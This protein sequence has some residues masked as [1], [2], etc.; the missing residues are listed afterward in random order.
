MA[1]VDIIIRAFD[2]TGDAFKNVMSKTDS[3]EKTGATLQKVGLGMAAVGGV[4]TAGMV[5]AINTFRDFEYAM[6]NVQ[7]VSGAT[8]EELK[9]LTDF[10]RE[11]G[12]TTQ[13]S[14]KEVAEAQYYL[15]SAGLKTEE[16]MSTLGNVLNLAA[17]TQSDLARTSEM[18]TA[19]L[20]Q[21][22]LTAEESSRV[23][24]V[25]MKAISNSQATMDKLAYSMRY[26]GPVANSLGITLE[27]TTAYLMALYNAG[28][29]GE[30]AGTIL[31]G[32]FSRLLDVSGE[33]AE[34]LKQLGLS[35]EDVNPKMHSF[36]DILDKLANAG[37][38]TSEI[39]KIF[40]MEA[41]PGVAALMSIG[42]DEIAKYQEALEGAGGTAERAAKEQIN[43]LQGSLAILKSAF[44]E[45]QLSLAETVIPIV[46]DFVKKL[47]GLV[48]WFNQLPEPIK[49]V[50]GQFT[51]FGGVGLTVAGTLT[52]ITGTLMKLGAQFPILLSAASSTF[53]GISAGL[54]LLATNPQW[55]AITLAITGIITVI[56]LLYKNWDKV[57]AFFKVTGKII[58][59]LFEGIFD[60]LGKGWDVLIKGISELW[61]NY[62][63][64]LKS[65]V[66]FIVTIFAPIGEFFRKVFVGWIDEVKDNWNKL[67][68]F[69]K[70]L[71]N[72]FVE[73]WR[74][75]FEALK[76][77]FFGWVDA[78]KGAFDSVLGFFR[79]IGDGISWIWHKVVDGAKKMS[80]ALVGH[81]IIPDMVKDIEKEF[82]AMGGFAEVIAT[83]ISQSFKKNLSDVSVV[84][85]AQGG[86][87]GSGTNVRNNI[88]IQVKEVADLSKLLKALSQGV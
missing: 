88:T 54:K 27:E 26:V 35:V 1:N 69:I 67:I 47:T 30:Q 66:N 70:A 37:A 51:L 76:K 45:L 85:V 65:V 58:V 72:G 81:S 41:G 11:M 84:G 57:V 40:G 17:G 9:K 14:A 56:T 60:V 13:F 74:G 52:M 16:I 86:R 63:D 21:F 12:T 10:A 29:K 25:F 34:T 75:V 33:A 53:K 83:D 32:A 2:K 71:W 19:T 3:L 5:S 49:K 77:I 46:S 55:L 31:R 78:I 39:I 44:Q 61:G 36:K 80:D 24:D 68:D 7:V 50:I 22:N 87:A 15:A 73:F 64:Y 48:N 43:T 28:F 42:R 6:K 18:V 23:A 62:V 59:N 82:K 38:S 8:G 4:I 79:K 20:S